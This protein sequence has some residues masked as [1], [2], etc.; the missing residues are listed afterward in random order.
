MLKPV[1]VAPRA[2]LSEQ[3][4]SEDDDI[5]S[6]ARS[7]AH[8]LRPLLVFLNDLYDVTLSSDVPS[9][10]QSLP[11]AAAAARETVEPAASASSLP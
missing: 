2:H 3:S 6:F 4:F 10:E 9:Q 8:N 7:N 11:A 5:V 1:Q